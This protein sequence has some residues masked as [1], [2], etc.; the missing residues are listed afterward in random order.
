VVANPGA[1]VGAL[2]LISICLIASVALFGRQ[3]IQ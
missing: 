2:V 1:I 3:E